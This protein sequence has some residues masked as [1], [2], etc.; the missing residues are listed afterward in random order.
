MAGGGRKRAA[1]ASPR[2]PPAPPKR[3]KTADTTAA[4]SSPPGSLTDDDEVSFKPCAPR[5]SPNGFI[6]PDPLPPGHVLTDTRGQ[7]W[8]LGKSIG[9][10]GFG[11]IYA[12]SKVDGDEGER[13]EEYV[14]KVVSE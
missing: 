12:S 3:A 5:R 13:E 10:G 4:A 14:V 6:L 1:A 7:R 11:E 8:R 9:L 2:T